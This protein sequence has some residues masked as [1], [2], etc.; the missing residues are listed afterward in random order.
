MSQHFIKGKSIYLILMLLP[1][2]VSLIHAQ[3]VELNRSYPLHITSGQGQNSPASGTLNIVAVMVEFQADDN[4][5]TSGNGTFADDAVP[6]L[7]NPGTN[8]DALPHNREFFQA[9]LEFVRNYYQRVSGGLLEIEY[10]VLPGIIQLD[11]PMEY[12]SPIG[13]EPGFEPV[14]KMSEEVW[15]KFAQ[16]S[17][18]NPDGLNPNETVFVIFHAGIGRDIELTGTILDKT[19]QDIPSVYLSQNSFKRLLADP[20]FSGFPTGFDGFFIKNTI[21]SPRTLSRSGTD[22]SGDRFVISLSANALLTAQIGSHL[23]L[24]D[25]F[26]TDDGSSGIGAFGLMDGAGIFAFNGLFPP[27]P[28]AWEKYHLGWAEPITVSI[29]NHSKIELTAQSLRSP[30]SI[31]RIELSSDEY[32]LLENRHRDPIGDG[33]TLTIRTTDGTDIQQRFT[34]RD[35]DFTTDNREFDQLLE[36][37]IIVDVSNYDWALPGGYDSQNDRELNGGI[38]IWHINESV[39]RQ[40]I[41]E[42]RVNANPELKGVELKEADGAQDIGRPTTIGLSDNNPNGWA[43][44]FWWA[45]NNATV[46]SQT[47]SISLYE[48]RFG[49][50]TT[51]SN[52]SHR[53]APSFF[54]LHDFSEQL[55]IASVELSPVA[56]SN[57]DISERRNL[58]LD[59]KFTTPLDDDLLR[60]YP[61]SLSKQYNNDVPFIFI[62]ELNSLQALRLSENDWSLHPV[63]TGS[64]RSLLL[65]DPVILS[66]INHSDQQSIH[67]YQWNEIDNQFDEVWMT[68]VPAFPGLLSSTDG[69]EIEP[70]HSSIRISG[71]DGT[72][73]ENYN[74]SIQRTA[75]LDGRNAIL[76]GSVIQFNS[77]SGE[78]IFNSPFSEVSDNHR[79]YLSLVR[80]AHDSYDLIILGNDQIYV[81]KTAKIQE[82][83]LLADRPGIDWPAMTDFNHDGFLDLIFTDPVTG[84]LESLNINGSVTDYF[85]ILPPDG[86]TFTGTPLIADLNADGNLEVI[87][88]GYDSHSMYIYAYTNRGKPLD[89]FPLLTGSLDD[90]VGRLINPMLSGNSLYAISPNGNF[91]Q[92]HLPHLQDIKWG[93]KYGN[94]PWNKVTGSTD[95][96]VEPDRSFGLLNRSETYNWPNPATDETHIRFQMNRPGEVTIRIATLNGRQ[97][98]NRTVQT[99]GGAPE[100][101]EINTSTWASGGY[102]A[103]I[104]AKADDHEEQK[105]IKIGIAR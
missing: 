9:R 88:A 65:S 20:M 97:I 32:F 91:R 50:D 57:L 77:P 34:N 44:D 45:G 24:P 23:G 18:F 33:V 76:S 37:G 19:P 87:T 105:I 16:N 72:Q 6:Y 102:F 46:T 104:T 81:Q 63:S 89:P 3:D 49:P 41:G 5:F 2:S 69:L 28:S 58:F 82:R 26:N 43:F 101:L 90:H 12:Y 1:F 4:R 99:S 56:D 55:P 14:A 29:Q 54:E 42:N 85:P 75:V 53:G 48:N 83:K 31:A 79:H 40:T 52:R 60:L 70:D 86:I 35:T 80:T 8:V 103:L 62:P 66:K 27:E 95:E 93:S 68:D 17:S 71:I 64:F 39:I 7:L 84:S 38:L 67:A 78:M 59:G 13:E 100:E 47:G 51:P 92:W 96:L 25:L 22:I 15:L 73:I 98:Y 10:Q 21:I 36:P 61:Y 11:H 74:T 94:H 30:K